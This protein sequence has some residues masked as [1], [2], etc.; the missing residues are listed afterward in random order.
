MTLSILA[1]GLEFK[2]QQVMLELKSVA[3]SVSAYVVGKAKK[4]SFFISATAASV[5]KQLG[6]QVGPGMR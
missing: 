5:E 4:G 2:P 3:A 6:K 1:D